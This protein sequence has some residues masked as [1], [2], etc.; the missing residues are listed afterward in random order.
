MVQHLVRYGLDNGAGGH[1]IGGGPV[2]WACCNVTCSAG[3]RDVGVLQ[4]LTRHKVNY[5]PTLR[6]VIFRGTPENTRK[7]SRHS[8]AKKIMI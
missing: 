7:E 6:K 4:R 3:A 8:S 1:V 5:L 2:T